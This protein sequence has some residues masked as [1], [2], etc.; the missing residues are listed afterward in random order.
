MWP[1]VS[2]LSCVKQGVSVELTGFV[3]AVWWD[4]DALDGHMRGG[5]GG[6][7]NEER[8][9]APNTNPP[10]NDAKDSR[11]SIMHDEW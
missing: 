6:E 4:F 7:G 5:G 3:S 8:G 1:R 9:G 2:A 10:N 11:R